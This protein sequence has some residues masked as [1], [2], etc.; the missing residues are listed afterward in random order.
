MKTILNTLMLTTMAVT[1]FAAD[2]KL[3]F[4]VEF[5][6]TI[7]KVVMPAGQ[8]SVEMVTSRA[9]VIQIKNALEGKSAFVNLPTSSRTSSAEQKAEIVF[10]CG[11][12][13]CSIAKVA[14]LVGGSAISAWA[15]QDPEA[16]IVAVK[17]TPSL[18]KAD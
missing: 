10:R 9:N 5:P 8:Y 7:G 16:K 3:N 14:N 12:A 6:F 17:L 11:G 1:G 2:N 15:T 13:G 4:H 18:T